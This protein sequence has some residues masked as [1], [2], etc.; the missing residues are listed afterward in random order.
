MA[1]YPFGGETFTSISITD[2][3]IA[4]ENIYNGREVVFANMFGKPGNSGSPILDKKTMKVIG[5]FWG[6]ISKGNEMIHC[7]TSIRT[8]VKFLK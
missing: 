6:G 4:S 3:K 7:F 5:L 2:G 8:I 1:G